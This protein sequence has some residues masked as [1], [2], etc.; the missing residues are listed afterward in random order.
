MTRFVLDEMLP[1]AAASH[2]RDEYHHDAVHATEVG[3]GAA[4]DADIATYARAERRAVVT[5][6]VA[7]FAAEREVV[8]VFV[9][10]RKLPQGGAQ[11]R[12]LA[13]LLDAWAGENP[14]PYVGQHWPR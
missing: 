1:T 6:N 5:E 12:A 9:L 8:L 3:L 7:D 10:K 14:E 11:A 13:R 2:L 4:D